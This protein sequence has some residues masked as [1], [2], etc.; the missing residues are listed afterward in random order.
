[1]GTVIRPELSKRNKYW[2]EKHRYYELRHFCLQ[3]KTWKEFYSKLDGF[4]KNSGFKYDICNGG[5][6]SDPTYTAVEQREYYGERIEM[7]KKA[8]KETDEVIGDYIL[9]AVTQNLS[10]EH[11]RA[12]Y[13]IPCCKNTYYEL[14]RKFF[15][16]LDQARK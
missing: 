14:Y 5:E 3:Y 8:A 6:L 11:L 1:M 15:W 7:L 13:S 10:Y 12:R 16:L 9:K 4:Q 2:I